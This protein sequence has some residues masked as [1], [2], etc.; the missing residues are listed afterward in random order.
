MRGPIGGPC[1]QVRGDGCG[2]GSYRVLGRAER[3]R[4]RNGPEVPRDWDAFFSA[5]CHDTRRR[6]TLRSEEHTSE[7]QSPVHLV[8]RLLLEKKNTT[9]SSN[10]A[11]LLT[12]LTYCSRDH[13]YYSSSWCDSLSPCSRRVLAVLTRCMLSQRVRRLPNTS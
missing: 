4:A 7:L 11:P 12:L 1:S 6:R 3:V 9:K 2:G 10:L 13:Y 8:C 5:E